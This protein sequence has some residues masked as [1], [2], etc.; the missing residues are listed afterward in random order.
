MNILAIGNSFSEDAARYL[1]RI[2]RADGIPIDIANLYIGGCTLERHHRNLLSGESAYEL[3]YNGEN[4]GFFVSLD[5]ALLNR[6]W[7]VVTLQ[8]CSSSSFRT[9]TYFP[10]IHTLAEHI[11]KYVPKAKLLI[12]QTWAYEDDSTMLR[13]VAGYDIP[14]LMFADIRTAYA[15]VSTQINADGVIPSG[16]L[17]MDLLSRGIPKI[18]RDTF[19]ATLGLGRYALG[20][21]WYRCLTGRNAADNPFN[22]FDEAVSQEEQSIIKACVD[23]FSPII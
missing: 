10:Y 18:H 7:D 16:Q 2:A 17:F 12:H 19:H 20:L 15:Q 4:T 22:D 8:Q 3:Q 23:T 11:R 13:E 6:P 9:D 21:L 5:E 14:A 1:H